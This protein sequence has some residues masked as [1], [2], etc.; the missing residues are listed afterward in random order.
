MKKL[1][2]MAVVLTVVFAAHLYAKKASTTLYKIKGGIT[3]DAKLD[4]WKALGIKPIQLN[5]KEQVAIGGMIWDSAEV[6]PSADIYVTFTDDDI[7]LLA[8]V[9]SKQGIFNNKTEGNIYDGN[10]V[11]L[12]VG[13]DNS[14]PNREIYSQSDYQIGISPGSISKS[15][16]KYDPKPSIYVYN[17]NKQVTAGEVKSRATKKGYIL[18]ARI[19]A[20]VLEGYDIVEGL[21]I[22][23]DVALDDQ[24][25]RG[26]TR[27]IQLT[28]EGDKDDW[29]HPKN[30]GQADIKAKK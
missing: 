1:V 16:G 14:D 9:T 6:K 2:A 20:D 25:D 17:L 22:G 12:F 28:W 15:T 19:P 27:K 3:V 5:K 10:S 13:F 24:A 30:W 8:D 18:E 21:E 26:R 23:F 7:Y 29:Q 11:E 4:D